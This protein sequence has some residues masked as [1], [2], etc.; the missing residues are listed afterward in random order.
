MN[1]LGGYVHMSL[2]DITESRG[3]RVPLKLE[4]QVVLSHAMW[5][6]ATELR[7]SAKV[8]HDLDC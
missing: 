3:I 6:Q 7:S 1:M 5:G 2:H 4:W 8:E